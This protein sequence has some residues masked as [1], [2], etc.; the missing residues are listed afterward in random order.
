MGYTTDFEGEFTLDKPLTPEHRVYLTKFAETRRMK[1]NATVT[2][3]RSDSVREAVGLPVG[4]EGGYFVGAEGNFGQE[5]DADDVVAS[6]SSPT[7]QPNLWCQWVPNEEGTAIVWDGCE[8]FYDYAAWLAYLIEHF[9]APWG[10]TLNGEVTWQGE[11]PSDMGKLVVEDN[12][13]SEKQG[14]VVYD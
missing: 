1:R 8:K 5:F 2:E 13:V 7:G 12:R 9:L 14:R 4:K 3:K 10:Y 6:G 11:D